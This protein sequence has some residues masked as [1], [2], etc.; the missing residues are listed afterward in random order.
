MA[1]PHPI[2][3]SLAGSWRVAMTTTDRAGA[4]T[5]ADGLT[6]RV[7]LIGEGRYAREELEGSFAGARHEKLTLFGWNATRERF[8]YATADN[9][10]GVILLYVTAPSRSGGARGVELF[11]D[12]AA[13]DKDDAA[14]ASFVT[15]RTVLT[16]E[17]RDNRTLRNF[18]R[19]AGRPERPFLEYRYT[20]I[21]DPA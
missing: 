4:Q 11:A 21:G 17:D 6:S 16:L 8:E 15:V 2:V 3:A 10:D 5:R 20:R 9:H 12:Y 7:T 1:L 14:A 19:P 18:Y 13:P